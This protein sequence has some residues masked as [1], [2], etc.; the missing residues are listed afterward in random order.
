MINIWIYFTERRTGFDASRSLL[1]LKLL[2][3]KTT[4]K[5]FSM[6]I[7]IKEKDVN[8][9][10]TRNCHFIFACSNIAVNTAKVS[11]KRLSKYEEALQ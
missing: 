4:R 1:Y 6:I 10:N 9:Q 11:K 7:F 2:P 3:P 8:E 5:Q